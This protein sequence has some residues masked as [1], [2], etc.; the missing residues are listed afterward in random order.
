MCPDWQFSS[1]TEAKRH[2]SLIHPNYRK[3]ILP[4]TDQVFKCKFEKCGMIF[5]TYHKLAKHRTEKNHFVRNKR[6]SQQSTSSKQMIAAKRKKTSDKISGFFSQKRSEITPAVEIDN[7]DCSDEDAVQEE[8][9]HGE[10]AQVEVNED[11]SDVSEV[12]DE[13]QN[14]EDM[15]EEHHLERED[16]HLSIGEYVGA[17]YDDKQYTGRVKDIDGDDVQVDFME[18]DVNRN[19]QQTFLWPR[20]SDNLWVKKKDVL[21]VVSSPEEAKRGYKFTADICIIICELFWLHANNK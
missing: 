20:R 11:I 8:T 4:G 5:P 19:T 15:E 1:V 7:I 3:E 16:I 10:E 17:V 12:Q 14:V 6:A 18:P 21:C 2:V 13:A 9:T